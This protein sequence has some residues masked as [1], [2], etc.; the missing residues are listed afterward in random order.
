MNLL[1]D[2][3]MGEELP[4][5]QNNTLYAGVAILNAFFFCW[6]RLEYSCLSENQVFLDLKLFKIV[7]MLL[8]PKVLLALHNHYF[9]QREDGISSFL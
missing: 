1:F 3:V 6:C 5:V 8:E 4:L 2:F 9:E 7:K